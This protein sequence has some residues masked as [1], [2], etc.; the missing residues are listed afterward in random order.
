MHVRS[1]MLEAESDSSLRCSDKTLKS[2]FL[3]QTCK[4]ISLSHPQLP[5][6]L[7]STLTPQ[8]PCQM[9]NQPKAHPPPVQPPNPLIPQRPQP[10]PQ[11]LLPLLLRHRLILHRPRIHPL[12]L[13]LQLHPRLVRDLVHQAVHVV[14]R[15]ADG[16]G[17]GGGGLV[18]AG[19]DVEVFELGFEFVHYGRDLFGEER[20]D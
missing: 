11:S 3:Y 19:G 13:L 1:G 5:I 12:H 8:T 4:L 20:V 6:T 15:R 10:L 7:L 14:L 18:V 9:P 16:G 17:G 2:G